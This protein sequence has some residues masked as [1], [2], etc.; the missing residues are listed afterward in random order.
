MFQLT[1]VLKHCKSG[2]VLHHDIKSKNILIHTETLKFTSVVET[3]P[4][5]LRRT[6]QVFVMRPWVLGGNEYPASFSKCHVS[7]STGTLEYTPH[8]WF[9][10]KWYL[11]DLA[12]VWSVGVTLYRLVCGS[13]PFK[14]SKE[15]NGHLRFT[16]SLSQGKE[17]QGL[18]SY[19]IIHNRPNTFIL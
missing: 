2:G 9:I 19:V 1:E 15:K 7:L 4:K 17:L 8:E 6:L 13:L 12:T 10:Q 3:S 14:T 16:K 5:D 18:I 11:A